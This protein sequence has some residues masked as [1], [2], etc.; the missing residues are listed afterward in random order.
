MN[1]K[2]KLSTVIL[3]ILWILSVV[4]FYSYYTYQS[5]IRSL[6]TTP[7]PYTGSFIPFAV[8]L[9]YLFPLVLLI[10]KYSKLAQM[11]TIYRFANFFALLYGFV[12]FVAPLAMC[13][14]SLGS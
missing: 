7:E 9:L 10:R 12:A 14:A 2:Y 6:S 8:S 11:K 13:A 3:V 1:K 5:V 4:G